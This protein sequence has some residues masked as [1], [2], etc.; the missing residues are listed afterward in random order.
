M[1]S[2]DVKEEIRS[3]IDLVDFLEKRGVALRQTGPNLVGL[4]PV[5]KENSPSFNVRPAIQRFHCFGCGIKGDIFDLVQA[6]EN[7]TFPGAI[8]FLADYTG[9]QIRNEEQDEDYRKKK[10]LY[11]VCEVA[12]AWFRYNFRKLPDTHPAKVNFS[13]RKLLDHANQDKTIG[14]APYD[15]LID[16]L[17]KANYTI[18]EMNE[19][20]LVK[21]NDQQPGS[22]RDRF[23]NRIMWTISDASGRPIGFS[24]RRID[25]SSSAPKYLN[26]P[27]TPLYNKSTTLLGLETAKGS[28]VKEQK[29]YIVE[30]QTDVMALQ[31]AGILN[32][33]ASCGTAF[34]GLHAASLRRLSNIGKGSNKFTFV[35]CFDSD[36]AG[37]KAA[38]SVFQTIPEIQLSSMVASMTP[39][40]PE[41]VTL[42]L[43]PCDV[44]KDFGDEILRQ[45]LLS[46]VSL[47]MF[48]LQQEINNWDLTT[49]EGQ[50][51]FVTAA[52][53]HIANVTDSVQ[54]ESYLRQIAFMSGVPYSQLHNTPTA[55][56][57]QNT[58]AQPQNATMESAGKKEL[59]PQ[60]R[61]IAFL[62]QYPQVTRNLMIGKHLT[63][64]MFNNPEF[65][66]S[67]YNDTLSEEDEAYQL[68]FYDLNLPEE[69]SLAVDGIEHFLDTYIKAR[70]L[71]ESSQLQ[72]K[73]AA[74]MTS[75]SGN[76][77][78]EEMLKEQDALKQ[79]FSQR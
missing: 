38:T 22:F 26:S 47:T 59:T 78:L 41:G 76:E 36:T 45:L 27:Q 50:S 55:R 10:R 1:I 64:D 20:G 25:D 43:D 5:H 71:Q 31:A 16:F 12:S 62:L 4:C 79:K 40:T 3:K 63:F 48:I 11:E 60:D 2:N 52:Q 39:T 77:W 33:V 46:P 42:N 30:G 73:F 35:F 69:H 28:I 72:A 13:D 75:S 44:R 24:G 68:M 32:V 70:F 8:Q 61:V 14:F 37:L 17:A 18:Q 9:V 23:R 65:V 7:L 66:E 6:V 58:S 34:G 54:R 74:K 51:G 29:V 19:A 53:G 57:T 56:P 15:G 21:E 67:A 49:A